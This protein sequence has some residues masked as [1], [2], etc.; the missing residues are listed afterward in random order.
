VIGLLIALGTGLAVG[1]VFAFV[2][3]APPAPDTWAGVAGIVGIVAGWTII[4][5]WK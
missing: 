3:V 2:N 4:G 5:L 1:A